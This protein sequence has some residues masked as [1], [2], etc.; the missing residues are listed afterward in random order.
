LQAAVDGLTVANAVTLAGIGTLDTQAHAFALTGTLSGTG[1]ARKTGTGTLLL[2]GTNTHSGGTAITAGT[3][4]AGSNSALGSGTASISNGATLQAAVDGLSIANAVT[5][6]GISTLDTQTFGMTLSGQISGTGTARKIGTGTLTL[7]GTGSA[8]GGLDIAAGSLTNEGTLSVSGAATMSSGTVLTNAAGASLIVTGGVTGDGGAQTIDTAGLLDAAIDLGGGDDAVTVRGG[9]VTGAVATGEGDDLFSWL[10]GTVGSFLGGDGA[11]TATVASP[12]YDGSQLLDGGAGGPDRLYFNAVHFSTTG[13]QLSN[14][15]EVHLNSGTVASLS[16]TLDAG[17]LNIAAGATLAAYDGLAVS[18]DLTSQGTIDLADGSTVDVLSIGGNFTQSAA[19]LWLVDIDGSTGGTD[20]ITVTG[21]ANL[22]GTLDVNVVNPVST[23]Q[24]FTVL[25]AA[26]GVTNNGLTLTGGLPVAFKILYPNPN[27][28]VLAAEI[29]FNLP[30][31]DLNPNQ[32]NLADKL[33]KI[34]DAGTDGVAPVTNA[35]LGIGD[36]ATYKDALNQ[37]LPEPYLHAAM[38]GLAASTAF[39][40]TLI[41]CRVRD[42][43]S[44]FIAEGQ[45]IW[46]DTGGGYL[47]R[48]QT[49]NYLGAEETSWWLGGGAQVALAPD[50]LL[51]FAGRYEQVWQDVYSNART[52]GDRGH[53]GTSLTYESGPFLLAAAVSAGRGWLETDRNFAFNGFTGTASADHNVDTVGG[54]LRAAYLVQSGATYLK[55][56][57]DLDIT[58]VSYGDLSETGGNGAA[59]DIY[60]ASETVF[61]ATPM[62]EIGGEWQLENGVLVRP[63]ARGGATFYGNTSFDLSSHFKDG[64]SAVNGFETRNE[65]DGVLANIGAGLDVLMDD[66]TTLR[67]SYDGTFGDTTESHAGG[68]RAEFKF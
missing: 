68:I 19:A 18:G 13:S 28:V 51:G 65:L 15:E 43:A 56:M 21:T 48:D 58:Y 25:S 2:T 55:P 14:W 40:E 11:D 16:G 66:A 50:L 30:D 60:D 45:C 32:R 49:A 10:A 39:S 67:L 34:I 54:K 27:D 7:S 22:A 5:V 61:S 37:L 63:Y 33:N 4:A 26:G 23:S 62:I 24:Q 59:L 38:S 17:L 36:L 1:T 31:G 35:L 8:I 29:N 20:L 64:P 6:A 53:V 42:G 52:E 12:G 44:A 9:T 47:E 57:L 3:L 46:A 41:G